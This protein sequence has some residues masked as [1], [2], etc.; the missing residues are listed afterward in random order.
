MSELPVTLPE[1]HLMES[2]MGTIGMPALVC[3]TFIWASG[4]HDRHAV[5]A[6]LCRSRTLV[7]FAIGSS[8]CARAR[9]FFDLGGNTRAEDSSFFAQRV[10]LLSTYKGAGI[11]ELSS[12]YCDQLVASDLYGQDGT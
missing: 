1:S 7:Y 10:Q 2:S 6:F 9:Q 5:C 3:S 12:E 4:R 8:V 11:G